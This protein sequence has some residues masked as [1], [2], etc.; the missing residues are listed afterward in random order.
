MRALQGE[1]AYEGS[2]S[3]EHNPFD[4]GQQIVAPI[5][6][7][8]ERPMSRN[9]CPSA[10]FQQFQPRYQAG[11]RIL[12]AKRGYSAGDQ[13][14]CKRDTIQLSAH[15]R[16]I[17]RLGLGE[18]EVPPFRRDPL[19]KQ[20]Y[21]RIAQHRV[22][23]LPGV[24][25]KIERENAI[26]IFSLH[27]QQF[28]PRRQDVN[29]G[30]FLEEAVCERSNRVDQVLTAIEDDE[31]LFRTDRVQQLGSCVPRFQG[32]PQR[33][34]DSS[35]NLTRISQASQVNKMDSTVELLRHRMTGGDSNGRL[36]DSTGTEQSDEPIISN[37]ILDIVENRVAPNH[38]EQPRGQ[39][40]LV[41][42]TIALVDCTVF[43][44]SQLAD[45]GI[46]SSLYVC[47]IPVAEL[48]IR[49]RLA[50]G[51]D[52]DP[53]APLLHVDI[54]PDLIDEFLLSNHFTGTFGE[55]DQNIERPAA[56]GKHHT[57]APQNPL[58]G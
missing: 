23:L 46:T 17:R 31:Q 57:V 52:M 54:R 13:F 43:K 19:H 7:C 33:S 24:W 27:S 5:Q 55:I 32:K 56:E 38:L 51:S 25:R 21:R 18:N 22:C 47:D 20:L 39:S 2:N 35:R 50:N 8:P 40:N 44:T 42:G 15:L 37:P 49:K 16:D 36:P 4:V 12:D 34:S 1:M 9:R 14:N 6:R 53:E 29:L 48:P 45:E 26:A 30:R 11:D 28:A 41:L 3:P 10:Q 58:P